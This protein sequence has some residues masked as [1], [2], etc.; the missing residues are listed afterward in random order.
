M[1]ATLLGRE[2]KHA[3][4]VPN[5]Y[6]DKD[7]LTV[8]RENLHYSDG[9]IKPNLRMIEN[10]QRSYGITKPGFRNHD[11]KK[12]SEKVSRLDI[13]KSNTRQLVK[14]IAR[15]LR[16]GL[17]PRKDPPL[18]SV[19]GNIFLYGCDVSVPV[20]LKEKY[21]REAPNLSSRNRVMVL[22]IETDML[23]GTE[24]ILMCSVTSKE[25][26]TICVVESFMEGVPNP[27]QAIENAIEK[28][29]G[30]FVKE[31][32]INYTIHLC[33]T[34]VEA[35]LRCIKK[36]HEVKPEFLAIWNINFDIKKILQLL[37]EN[38]IDP[39]D[40]FS[41]PTVPKAYKYCYYKEGPENKLSSS[42]VLTPLDFN[43]RWHTLRTPASFY[44]ICAMSTYSYIRKAKGKSP[45]ALDDV[46]QKEV[47][48]KNPITGKDEKLTKLKIPEA[49]HLEK[50]AW[51]IFMQKHFK[52]EYVAY[53]LF[54]NISVEI[55]DEKTND[56]AITLSELTGIS[57]YEEFNSTSKQVAN[58]AHFMYLQEN[59]PELA[60]SVAP[61][62]LVDKDAF[63]IPKSNIIIA[64]S[65][66]LNQDTG[67]H[68]CSDLPTLK[69]LVRRDAADLDAKSA[70]PYGQIIANAGKSTKVFEMIEVENVNLADRLVVGLNMCA[71]DTNAYEFMRVMCKV[72]SPF[73][74]IDEFMNR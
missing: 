51:H 55:L 28:Y 7:D 26:A 9:T 50:G 19:T 39:A 23:D 30:R 10:V 44:V 60:C 6:N 25:V 43:E 52:A 72:P 1:T 38:N 12:E 13:H 8:I 61:N 58:E 5:R 24:Q 46:L 63:T 64:L 37:K 42:G 31:R 71:G 57:S 29:V 54:D 56:L 3:W 65:T 4:T 48:I 22:D 14:N 68:A 67:I 2:F 53:N 11:E 15:H 36:A 47:V 66:H 62:M 27:K 34:P 21:Q 32:N 45:G 74:I 73:D 41:D 40:I 69:S 49:A 20:L 35:V 16:I 59:P 70:Y 17:P 18:S 33:K